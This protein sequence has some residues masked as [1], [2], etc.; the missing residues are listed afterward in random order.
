MSHSIGHDVFE[1][2]RVGRVRVSTIAFDDPQDYGIA[3]APQMAYRAE[4]IVFVGERASVGALIRYGDVDRARWKH[5]GVLK[6][7]RR[8]ST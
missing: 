5:V 3:A 1:H 4:T 2:P 7:A 8:G 6:R